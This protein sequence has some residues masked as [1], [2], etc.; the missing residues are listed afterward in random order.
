MASYPEELLTIK[1]VIEPVQ[2][3]SLGP[4]LAKTAPG[5]KTTPKTT[6]S[7]PDSPWSNSTSSTP[8][9]GSNL[10][11]TLGHLTVTASSVTQDPLW[12]IVNATFMA[13]NHTDPN[14]TQ[15]CWLCYNLCPPF[16][17]AVGLNVSYNLSSDPNPP[18]CQWEEHKIGLMME[19]VWRQAVCLGTVPKD[20]TSICAQTIGNISLPGKNWLVPEVGGMVGLFTHGPN[21]MFKYKGF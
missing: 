7:G 4:N 1:Q 12:A 20:K 2:V 21:T 5:H 10:T 8:G 14:A 9:T 6:I 15:S 16:Y 11:N 19:E 13:L 3:H 17:E 18:Q